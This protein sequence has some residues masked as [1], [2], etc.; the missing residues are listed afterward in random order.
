MIVAKRETLLPIKARVVASIGRRGGA[1]EPNKP[2]GSSSSSSTPINV[3]K[4]ENSTGCDSTITAT[5][6]GGLSLK[7]NVSGIR[8]I[9]AASAVTAGSASRLYE[10]QNFFSAS[11]VGFQSL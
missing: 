1:S 7:F 10:A 3:L 5:G 8:S 9:R 6:L 11:A 4:R 2:C